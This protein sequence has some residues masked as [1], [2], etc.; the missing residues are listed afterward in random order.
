[1]P[2][3]ALEGFLSCTNTMGALEVDHVMGALEVDYVMGTL[4]VD[5]VTSALEEALEVG[6]T[7]AVFAIG[8]S[9]MGAAFAIAVTG[10]AFAIAVAVFAS[11]AALHMFILMTPA[12]VSAIA[13]NVSESA[14][15]TLQ[16]KLIGV[17]LDDRFVVWLDPRLYLQ[18]ESWS[19]QCFQSLHSK[20]SHCWKL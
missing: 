15:A 2:V 9:F 6:D 20:L 14:S 19:L 10:A 12:A 3:A 13:S 16:G 11:A 8:V 17:H 1:M 5:H 18:F 4:E 7:I